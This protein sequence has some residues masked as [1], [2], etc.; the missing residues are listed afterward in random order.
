MKVEQLLKIELQTASSSEIRDA[1]MDESLQKLICKIDGSADPDS[2]SVLTHII[3]L[4]RLT[5]D[6][7]IGAVCL[8]PSLTP[9]EREM[10]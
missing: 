7:N 6:Y 1:L 10:Q 3:Y 4:T 5:V 8:L 2:V 9:S